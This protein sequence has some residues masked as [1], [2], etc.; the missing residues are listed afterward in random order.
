MCHKFLYFFLHI[1]FISGFGLYQTFKRLDAVLM[2]FK[3]CDKGMLL[4]GQPAHDDVIKWKHFPRYWPFVQGIHRP[5]VNS[6]H[7]GQ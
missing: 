1:F 6:P 4:V 7:K 3:C 5:P 2:M